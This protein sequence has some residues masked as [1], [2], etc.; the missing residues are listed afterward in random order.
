[1][2]KKVSITD[3][4][5]LDNRP[6]IGGFYDSSNMIPI[7]DGKGIGATVNIANQEIEGT[8]A[9]F[10][11][12]VNFTYGRTESKAFVLCDNT[13]IFSSTTGGSNW[14]ALGN[15]AG[16][17]N[18]LIADQN[19]IIWVASDGALQYWTA[20]ATRVW[21]DPTYAFTNGTANVY[22]PAAL[23]QN[24]V[25]FGDGNIIARIDVSGGGAGSF[26]ASALTLPAGYIITSIVQAGYDYRKAIIS[27]NRNNVGA[28]FEWDCIADEPS[29]IFQLNQEVFSLL[30]HNNRIFAMFSDSN[31]YE[32][33]SY[34]PQILFRIPDTKDTDVNSSIKDN[35]IVSAGNK[36][37][38]GTHNS[39]FTRN[40]S[41]LWCYDLESG[42]GY[43]VGPLS[44]NERYV[45]SSSYGAKCLFSLRVGSTRR[46]LIGQESELSAD[47][48]LDSVI[49]GTAPT[50]PAYYVSPIISDVK[51]KL[52]G[53][54]FKISPQQ[55]MNTGINGFS[56][57]ILASY[58]V[59]DSLLWNYAQ[60]DGTEAASNLVSV[61]QTLS[62]AGSFSIGAVGDEVTILSG[63]NA[64]YTQRITTAVTSADP[65]VYT[66]D[67]NM[68]GN[69]V[70]GTYFTIQK[71]KKLNTTAT[72]LTSGS[73]IFIPCPDQPE[74][75]KLLI[76]IQLTVTT[77]FPVLSDLD[78][79]YDTIQGELGL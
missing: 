20:E 69:N 50:L 63:A 61:D 73:N 17:S 75:R 56:V 35:M 44:A 43:Y 12:P 32:I 14:A 68:A 26:T 23:V 67:G 72:T 9:N 10:T 78:I 48:R 55:A 52:R 1:M 15:N 22:H 53:I 8:L 57:S 70:N 37:Y 45:S 42:F 38:F 74:F 36:L 47:G 40:R 11:T 59:F 76:K 79:I 31:L 5:G 62:A 54:K 77:G 28:I 27:A 65:Y 51:S 49:F 18:N 34:P 7:D 4:K 58:Y 3:F 66:L 64:G 33:T 60:Q 24:Y 6:V 16:F 39:S 19:D 71:F 46:I 2:L 29:S 21:T 25:L 13:Y 41:G 30:N